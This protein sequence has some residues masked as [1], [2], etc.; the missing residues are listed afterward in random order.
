[1]KAKPKA[2]MLDVVHVTTA[3]A[4]VVSVEN[5]I[6]DLYRLV[7]G[8]FELTKLSNITDVVL[9]RDSTGAKRKRP[10]TLPMVGDDVRGPCVIVG[11]KGNAFRSLTTME[12]AA[13]MAFVKERQEKRK[14]HEAT[15]AEAE[16]VDPPMCACR[17]PN[18][19][20]RAS[21]NTKVGIG[22]CHTCGGYV[23]L[24]INPEADKLIP[25]DECG[26]AFRLAM[27]GKH[28]GYDP[29]VQAHAWFRHGWEARGKA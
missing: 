15:R 5:N 7:G 25:R 14:A 12:Q 4:R 13:A 9:L 23:D 17:E 29:S 27:K 3:G 16:P 2:K 19:A 11:A 21:A 8:I 18:R 24:N 22:Y 6:A 1:M 28:Y 26:A 20:T 10:L